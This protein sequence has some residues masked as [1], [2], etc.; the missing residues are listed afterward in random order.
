MQKRELQHFLKNGL[1]NLQESRHTGLFTF[2][3]VT[4]IAK[5]GEKRYDEYPKSGVIATGAS[6][7]QKCCEFVSQYFNRPADDRIAHYRESEK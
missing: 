4:N 6:P 5:H 7:E 3:Y 2:R 1:Q